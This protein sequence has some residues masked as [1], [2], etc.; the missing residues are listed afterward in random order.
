MLPLYRPRY[1]V[2]ITFCFEKILYI[3]EHKMVRS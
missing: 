1:F 3:Y 2:E